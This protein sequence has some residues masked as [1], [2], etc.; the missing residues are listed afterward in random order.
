M[1]LQYNPAYQEILAEFQE[2]ARNW[3]LES[4]S[5]IVDAGAGTGNFSLAASRIHPGSLTVHLEP[6]LRMIARARAKAGETPP[7]NLRMVR[8]RIE[9]DCIRSN[10]VSAMMCVH[11][12]Y[13]LPNPRDALATMH[14]WLLPAGRIFLCDLGRIVD[15]NDWT[16]FFIGHLRRR[17]GVI[18]TARILWKGRVVAQQN[19]IIRD[20]QRDG[21]YWTHSPA[22]FADIVEQTGFHVLSVRPCNRGYS[23]LVV[24][25]K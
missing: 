22:Q 14:R 25:Q 15:L 21:T 3:P 17:F 11:V 2:E 13:S 7:A 16:R 12:L 6:D 24:A 20:R 23:H 1:F 19:R 4:D 10:S 5:V 9:D 18:G 8:G